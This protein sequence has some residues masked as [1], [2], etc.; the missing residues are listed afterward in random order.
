M[1]LPGDS[2]L[3]QRFLFIDLYRS[4][5]IFFMLE[6]HVA[7]VVL[8]Q[9][10]QQTWWFRLHE[11]FHG[12]TAPAFLFGA[13]LTF[14][15]STRKRWEEFHSWGPRLARRIGRLLFVLMLGLALHLPFL[16]ARKTIL[17]GS[18]QD[19][20]QLFQCDVLICIGVGLLALHAVLFF[21]KTEARFFGLVLTIAL[22]VVFLTPIVWEIDFLNILPIPLAQ[23]MNSRHGSQFPLFP[24]VGFLFMGVIVSWEFRVFV[25]RHQ[26]VLFVRR[27]LLLGAVSVIAG[28]AAE[29][30][31][32]RWYAHSDF[33]YTGPP[34]FFVRSGVLM[35]MIAGFWHLERMISS[36]RRVLTVFGRESLFIYVLHLVLI[37][38]SVM[39]APVNL[40]AFMAG[41]LGVFSSLL[42]C[43]LFITAMLGIAL[44]WN[45][46]KEKHFRW[47]RLIQLV[48]CAAVLYVL[49]NWDY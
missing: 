8:A 33:W 22:A 44:G 24:Y 40:Q 29:L 42:A 21:L 39:N 30:I 25:E 18:A 20:L 34:Y 9:E 41:S 6:G 35:M 23:L 31:P 12:I 1:K 46:L 32:V 19:F 48:A 45:T 16:S 37:Y 47:Y 14:V 13:G 28:I 27:L 15:I 38:G 10:F 43:I 3:S 2:V 26:E 5:V 36:Q 11:L 17:E 4:A 7:R 49:F